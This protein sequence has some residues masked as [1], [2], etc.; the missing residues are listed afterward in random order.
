MK[1]LI[2]VSVIGSPF[3]LVQAQASLPECKTPVLSDLRWIRDAGL[4]AQ[5]QDD[6]IG[7]GFLWATPKEQEKLGAEAHRAGRCGGFEALTTDQKGNVDSKELIKQL[8]ERVVS[9]RKVHAL[10]LKLDRKASTSA[11]IELLDAKRIQSDITWFSSFPTR[12]NKAPDAN[13]PVEALKQKLDEIIQTAGAQNAWITPNVSVELVT[14]KSTPQKSIRLTLKGAKAPTE[15]VVLGGHLDSINQHGGTSAPGADDN[16]SGTSVLI[17]VLR[18]L[19]TSSKAPDR[20]I[21]FYWYAG[22]ESG[23]LGSAEIASTAKKAALDVVGVLQL[24]M[25]LHPGTGEATVASM[26]DFTSPWLRSFLVQINDLYVKAKFI[27]DECGYGCSDH[28]SWFRQGY[29]SVMPFEAAFDDMNSSLHTSQ[30]VINSR[31]SFT[32]SLIFAKLALAYALELGN[33]SLREGH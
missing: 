29:P 31:S 13:K 8:K 7:V 21:Q 30:D 2:F 19:L 28:A 9:S 3:A 1:K 27:D 33:S 12:F 20:S 6:S 4:S 24:D 22:E 14:H 10:S 32:H 23:L 18:V 11:A 5:N 16:A 15:F 17:D 25:T 26:T